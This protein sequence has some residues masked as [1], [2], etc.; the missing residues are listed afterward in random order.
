MLEL[1]LGPPEVLVPAFSTLVLCRP[2][3]HGLTGFRPGI[4]WY[5]VGWP[6]RGARRALREGKTYPTDEEQQASACNRRAAQHDEEL[7][8]LLWKPCSL[9]SVPARTSTGNCIGGRALTDARTLER[10]PREVWIR[11]RPGFA[12][13]IFQKFMSPILRGDRLCV[14]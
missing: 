8:L 2:D 10:S 7:R 14:K 3:R 4:G 13:R 1:I 5:R 6:W 9:R 12:C 11:R